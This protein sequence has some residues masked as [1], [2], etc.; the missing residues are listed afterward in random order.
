MSSLITLVVSVLVFGVIILVHE[1]GHFLA[2]RRFGIRVMEFSIGF[3]P[4]LWT[5]I[6]NG[7][8]YS[9]RLIP[10][11]GYN[12]MDGYETD[13]EEEDCPAQP[14]AVAQP[15]VVCGKTYPEATAWQRFFVIAAGA[16]MNFLLGFV[17]LVIL[18]SYR[19]VL[20]SKIIYD[21]TDNARSQATGLQPEDE[22][23]A[24][25]GHHCFVAEDVYY[26]LQRTTDFTADFTVLRD[27]KRVVVPD[28]QFDSTVDE[29][30]NVS[31]VLDFRVYGIQV[32]PRS[33]FKTA[34]DYFIYYARI[35]LRGF[36]DLFVGRVGLQDLSGPVGVVT[37]VGQAVGD[38]W[39]TVLELSALLTINLGIFNLL[40]VPGLDGG[41]LLFLAWEG[42]TR[43]P[44]PER[45]QL[46]I[47]TAGILMLL[48][49]MIL[50]T[51]QDVFRIL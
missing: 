7:T 12:L 30:G 20:T 27:G 11:G 51:W 33:V 3:G 32:S 10:I 14:P 25:N 18:L 41:K 43:H 46:V 48:G 2:A 9:L 5:K 8:R 39:R 22:I 23:L 29:D 37:A 4:A 15:L 34:I 6:K 19:Q 40:P 13:E 42:I 21:F 31:M 16:A 1:L 17:L 35:I 28:V 44:V 50:V 45:L 24:I 47:N 26:E 36:S 49:L 38:G